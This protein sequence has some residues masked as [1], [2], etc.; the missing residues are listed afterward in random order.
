MPEGKHILS[1]FDD[2]L[3]ALRG[4][5]LLMASLTERNLQNAM[6]CLLKE[7]LDLCA[8]AVADEEEIDLLQKKV[9]ND[10][11]EVLLRFQ[12]VASDLRN[13]IATMRFAA[14]LE[15]V[16]DQARKIARRGLKLHNNSALAETSSIEPMFL[17]STL[18]F[19][20]SVRAFTNSD[21][22]LAQS[23]RIRDRK[24]DQMNR[25]TAQLL[26]EKM[27][28]DPERIKDY[29][30]LLFI[31]RHLERVGDHATNIA[32]DAVYA[33]AAEDIRYPNNS[34]EFAAD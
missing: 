19:R 12:P 32:E 34:L 13:V 3:A 18:L 30:D 8:S 16:A 9:D 27:S 5:A 11:V 2:A 17:E 4:C 28:V 21:A 10:G 7:N 20:E 24:L 15:R 6:G 31:A 23:L 14:N 22:D 26:T 29:L 25:Q 33:A 1:G